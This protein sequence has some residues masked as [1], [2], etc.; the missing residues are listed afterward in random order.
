[1]QNTPI[2]VG[3]SS[4]SRTLLSRTHSSFGSYV[5]DYVVADLAEADERL[6]DLE[7]E[8]EAALAQLESLKAKSSTRSRPRTTGPLPDADA[9]SSYIEQRSAWVQEELKVSDSY[10]P[11]RAFRVLTR[12]AKAT[13]ISRTQDSSRSARTSSI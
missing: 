4:L 11:F 6:K 13:D 2:L 12:S 9:V 7:E 8:D 3:V 5:V 1:M 10:Q